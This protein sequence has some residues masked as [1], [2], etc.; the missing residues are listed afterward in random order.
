MTRNEAKAIIGRLAEEKGRKVKEFEQCRTDD[1][2]RA[3]AFLKATNDPEVL[4]IPRAEPR[5]EDAAAAL[6]ELR[7]RYVHGWRERRKE[8]GHP[9]AGLREWARRLASMKG[10]EALP[11]ILEVCGQTREEMGGEFLA[12]IIRNQERFALEAGEVVGGF[13][14]ADAGEIR[15]RVDGGE[16]RAIP[17]GYGDGSFRIEARKG[18]ATGRGAMVEASESLE[19]AGYD[20]CPFYPAMTLP[21]G[22]YEIRAEEGFCSITYII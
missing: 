8:E 21:A 12:Y 15:Y 5:P 14:M 13:Y 7:R 9:P 10:E 2:R 6:V 22:R 3:L 18:R 19:I 11:E 17:N 20:C 1:E 4:T 16:P